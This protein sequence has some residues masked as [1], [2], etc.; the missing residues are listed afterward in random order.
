MLPLALLMSAVAVLPA[1]SQAPIRWGFDG[2]VDAMVSGT[3]LLAA[4][5][6]AAVLAVL[7]AAAVSGLA[8]L[9]PAQ[10]S[11]W[12]LACSG[13]VGAAAATSYALVVLTARASS[14]MAGAVVWAVLGVLLAAAIWG[15]IGYAVHG[16]QRPSL[17]QVWESIPELDRVDRAG[18]GHV[19]DLPWSS[20]TGSRSLRGVSAFLVLVFLTVGALLAFL[21]SG[22]A[23]TSLLVAV[24][25]VAAGLAYACSEVQVYVDSSGLRVRLARLPVTVL[26][27]RAEEVLGVQVRDLDPLAWGGWGLRWLPGSTA[28]I[29][30]GGPGIVIHRRSGRRLA[31][32][33]R[34]GEQAAAAGAAALRGAA[35]QSRAESAS[36]R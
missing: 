32:E 13:A 18:G 26:R 27:A 22:W 19:P 28:Y 9:V 10:G 6:T 30:A 20:R 24:G 7:L 8:R 35:A 3:G 29:G 23:Q 16:D 11:R 31:I 2:Q 34:D 5:F 25:L 1:P 17:A 33:L 36:S 15:R 14:G 4:T 21:G 12:L